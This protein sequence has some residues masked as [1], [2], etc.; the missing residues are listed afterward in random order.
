M[1]RGELVARRKGLKRWDEITVDGWLSLL[2]D[3]TVMS[4]LMMQIFSRLYHSTD[5]MDNAKNIAAD[6]HMEYRALNAG[7]GWAGNKIRD[8]YEKGLLL[9]Y[10]SPVGSET[11][12]EEAESEEFTLK[13]NR[14]TITRHPWEYVFDGTEG[15]DGIYFWVLKPEAVQAYRELVDADITRRDQIS[16]MLASDVTSSGV[17]GNLFLESSETTV[18]RLRRFMDEREDF[19]R[20][21]MTA[22]PCCAVCGA[23]RISL[24]HA[25]PYGMEGETKKGLLF[26]PTHG[27]LFAAHLISFADD[28]TLLISPRLTEEEIQIYGLQG[29][30]KAHSS[31]SRYRMA[32]HRKIFN[33]EARK[34]K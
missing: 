18:A 19:R 2:A 33:Q 4:R 31:F 24:L 14:K 17:E 27:A 5:Y 32:E 28:G 22:H 10:E 6:L 1:Q 12:E 15:E 20:K 9:T 16:R 29:R 25:L 34:R 8:M 21:S 13:E 7:V 3:K 30:E 11:V 23:D 26:C